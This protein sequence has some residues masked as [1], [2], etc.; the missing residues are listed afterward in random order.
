MVDIALAFGCSVSSVLEKIPANELP[1][2]VARVLKREGY[3]VDRE[4]IERQK[5]QARR[6]EIQ[7]FLQQAREKWSK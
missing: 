3:V 4:E 6:L 5:K 2:F 7:Q 1:L